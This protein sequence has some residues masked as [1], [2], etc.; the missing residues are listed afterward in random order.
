MVVN[1]GSVDRVLRIVMGI[2][3][4]SLFFMLQGNTRYWGLLGLVPLFTGVFRF[5]PA[6]SLIGVNTCP[7]NKGKG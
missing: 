3:V 4:L 6:Y 1:V 7:M 5:C 2:A